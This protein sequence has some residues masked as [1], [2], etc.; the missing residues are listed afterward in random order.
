MPLKTKQEKDGGMNDNANYLECTDLRIGEIQK[1]E[2]NF[3]FKAR[4]NPKSR[5]FNPNLGGVNN[6]K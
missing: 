5:L 3:G 4:F 2:C 1:I 6:R